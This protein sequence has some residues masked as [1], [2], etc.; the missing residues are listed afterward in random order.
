MNSPILSCRPVRRA[1]TLVELLVVIV[2]IALLAGLTIPAVNAAREA[3]RRAQCIDR[4]RQVGTAFHTYANL[5]KGL[6]GHVNALPH[7]TD[8][9]TPVNSVYLSWVEETLPQLGE[10]K[11]YEILTLQGRTLSSDASAAMVTLPVVLCPS[12]ND[13]QSDFAPL[14][15]VV[16]CGPTEFNGKATP[17]RIYGCSASHFTLFKDRRPS[18]SN[19]KRVKLEEIPDGTSNTVLMSENLQA[20]TWAL[21]TWTTSPASS[22]WNGADAMKTTSGA[23]ITFTRNNTVISYLGFVWNNVVNIDLV[24]SPTVPIVKMNGLRKNPDN[25]GLADLY[26]VDSVDTYK[27]YLFARPSSNHPGVV[28]VLYA[29]N[30]VKT[31]SDAVDL[32]A[33]LG[34]VCPDD[35]MALKAVTTPATDNKQGGLGW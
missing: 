26:Q 13:F 24:N 2:I 25:V 3:G 15:F 12:N 30:T 27:R 34:A 8:L 6:P 11:R 9:A 14:S 20:G 23:T 16:N 35:A 4:M 5:N 28:N 29:D 19:N 31:P 33:Y 10:N 32:I 17:E 7:L 18:A 21:P 1:F 22:S